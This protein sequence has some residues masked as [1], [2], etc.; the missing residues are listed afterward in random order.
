MYYLTLFLQYPEKWAAGGQSSC[1]SVEENE[2]QTY[3]AILPGLHR[4]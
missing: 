4:Q 2:T 3:E 1:F